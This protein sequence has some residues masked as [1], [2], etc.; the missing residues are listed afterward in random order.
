LAFRFGDMALDGV[1]RELRSGSA[2]RSIEPQVFDLLEFLV[3]NR[4]RVVSRD[5]LLAAVWNGRIV[6]DSAID[7]RINAARRAI[8]DDGEHQRW[9]RTIARKGFRFVGDVRE[10]LGS[11]SP[12]GRTSPVQSKPSVAVLP[13]A[14]MSGDLEQEYF[15]DGITEDVITDLSRFRLLD[16]VASTV[17]SRYR[18]TSDVQRIG[19][20]LGVAFAVLGSV[21]RLGHRIRLT[22]QLVDTASGNQVWAE[23]FDRGGE[24]FF[25]AADDLVRTI[26]GTVAGRLQAAGLDRV[27]RK[28]P[29][30]LA[31][32]DCV[33]RAR[34]VRMR[35][36]DPEAEAELQRLY[37]QAVALDPAYGRAYAGLAMVRMRAWF[38][39]PT[40]SDAGLEH[41]CRLAQQAAALDQDDSECQEAVGWILLHRQCFD[42]AEQYY[43]RALEL[44]PNSP[45]ELATMGALIGYLGRPEE[46]IAWFEQARRVDPFFDP[47]WYWHLFGTTCFNARRYD[48]AVAAYGRSTTPPVWVVAYLA[49]SHALAGRSEQAADCAAEVVRRSPHFS[50]AILAAKEP[51][52]LPVDRAHLLDGLRKAGLPERADPETGGQDD[53][54]R[55]AGPPES[56]PSIAVLP[57]HNLSGDPEQQYFSDGITEDIITDLSKV[58]A[59]HVVSRNTAFTLKGKPV[60]IAEVAQ[61]LKVGHIVEGSVRKAGGRVRITAQLIDASKDSHVWGE[62]YDRDLNDIFALQDE[63]AQA[64]VAALKVR[65]LPAEKRAIENRPTRDADAYQIYLQCRYHY[66]RHG[67]KNLEIAIRFGQRALEIDPQYARAWALIAHCQ[68]GLCIRG[69]S[70]ES[71]LAA[72]EMALSLDPTLAEAHSARGRVLCDLGRYDEAVVELEES[73]RLDPDSADVRVDFGRC[74]FLFGRYEEAIEHLERGA[75]LSEERYVPL[76]FAAQ[77]YRT[78][79]RDCEARAAARRAL[80]RIEREIALHPE[81]ALALSFGVCMFAQLGD[82]ERAK[83]WISRALIVAPDDPMIRYN[84]ACGLAQMGETDRALDLLESARKMSNFAI[85]PRIESDS[86]LAPLHGHPR[87][88]ALVADA[89]ARLAAAPNAPANEAG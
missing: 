25:A 1:R 48:D 4:D 26:A 57:F 71:G 64:I 61:Q 19:R 18:D 17:S 31:A 45:D 65:L 37:E 75:A 40:G 34:A 68:S 85:I 74:C 56:K 54:G 39:D 76:A 8:G 70:D 89:E 5:D 87:F 41:A 83:E 11:T 42:L 14:N 15:S 55:L 21:R 59:L 79:G 63:I 32:Y 27:R 47:S 28:P 22:A 72:A 82:K 43:R 23:R 69:R 62:R 35:V 86:D 73:V 46:G 50:A 67:L 49:A 80:E 36:G 52:K 77:A 44:N 13:F 60:D 29:A 10:D 58:S 3:T 66:L 24:D 84:L 16:V 51:Y 88:Q 30:N 7:A 20:E 2:V 6:S 12:S 33:L 53:S 78:L 9:I 38:R 81:N